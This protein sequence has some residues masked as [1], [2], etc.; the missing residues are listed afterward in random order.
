MII[1][2]LLDKNTK[3]ILAF[4]LAEKLENSIGILGDKKTKSFYPAS[5]LFV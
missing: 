1:V 2:I 4:C 3:S 5:L